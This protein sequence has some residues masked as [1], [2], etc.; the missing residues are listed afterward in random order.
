M[1]KKSIHDSSTKNSIII[2]TK[3]KLYILDNELRTV[4]QCKASD[5]PQNVK[6]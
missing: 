1:N 5:V 6:M 2:I 4:K 3:N